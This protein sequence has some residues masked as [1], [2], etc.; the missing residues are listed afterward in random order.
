MSIANQMPGESYQ[1][2]SPG[3]GGQ[4]EMVAGGQPGRFDSEDVVDLL[5]A[6]QAAT[7]FFRYG[8]PDPALAWRQYQSA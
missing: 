2:I 5:R 6:E 8:K 4:V 3:S 1:L 7:H